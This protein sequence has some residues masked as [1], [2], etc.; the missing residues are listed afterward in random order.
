VVASNFILMGCISEVTMDA[1]L[2][3]PM[4]ERERRTMP[5][6]IGVD[7]LEA[8][9]IAAA[10]KGISVVEYITRNILEVANRDIEEGHRARTE[11]PPPKKRPRGD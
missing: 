10:Y 4:T 6:R 5:V 11:P 3:R 1:L 9:K 8:A 7:A 2:E